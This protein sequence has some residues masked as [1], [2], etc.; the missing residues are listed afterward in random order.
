MTGPSPHVSRIAPAVVAFCFDASTPS[1]IAGGTSATGSSVAFVPVSAGL[2]A[3]LSSGARVA[4]VGQ[5]STFLVLAS[6][7]LSRPCA[8][9]VSAGSLPGGFSDAGAL[10]TATFSRQ[11]AVAKSQRDTPRH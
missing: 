4:L 1:R 7:T 10:D 3:E 5:S 8:I 11:P 9:V 6:F 2:G